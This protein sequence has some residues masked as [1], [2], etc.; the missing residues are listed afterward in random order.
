MTDNKQIA[1]LAGDGI[2]PEVMEVTLEILSKALDDEFKNSKNDFKFV[3]AQVGGVAIDAHGHPL[4]PETLK[5]C[6]ESG[7]VLF[8]SVGGPKWEKTTP[9]YTTRTWCFTTFKKT[10]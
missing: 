2:G 3:E 10:F 4:P 6:E 5:I 1:V 9:F 8:G 7:A